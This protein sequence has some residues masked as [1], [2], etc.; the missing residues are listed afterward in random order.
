MKHLFL[1][2]SVLAAMT[3]FTSC[4]K[5]DDT[6]E[7]FQLL[8]GVVWESDSLL[9][10]GADASGEGQ[11][12]E[13]FRGEA[14]F[15]EDFTGTFGSYEG[16]WKFA[17]DETELVIQSDS[18]PIPMLSTKIQELTGESLKVTTSFPDFQN[19]GGPALQIRLTFTAQ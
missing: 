17:Q 19:P 8:T 15:R 3:I 2:F 5:E 4:D 13:D 18:L 10:N 1:I 9:V 16:T 11:M 14:R 12:L 6:S 7:R